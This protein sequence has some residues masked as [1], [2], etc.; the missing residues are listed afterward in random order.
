MI[1]LL[2]KIILVY[3]CS[4]QGHG[5]VDSAKKEVAGLVSKIEVAKKQIE[6]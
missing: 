4:P 5:E 2:I 3:A 6:M 1:I